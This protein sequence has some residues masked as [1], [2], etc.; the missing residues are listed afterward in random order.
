MF[1]AAH[2]GRIL[3]SSGEREIRVPGAEDL[4]LL[5]TMSEDEDA[6]R[7]LAAKPEFDRVLYNEKLTSIGLAA[8]TQ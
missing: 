4:A 6:V 8:Y 1:A 5:L 3:N 2:V 7:Q